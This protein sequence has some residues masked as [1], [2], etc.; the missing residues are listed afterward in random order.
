ME[1]HDTEN[2]H[3]SYTSR[4]EVPQFPK[5]QNGASLQGKHETVDHDSLLFTLLIAS[6]MRASFGTKTTVLTYHKLSSGYFGMDVWLGLPWPKLF[7]KLSCNFFKEMR[8]CR[9]PG[10]P[11]Q[12]APQDLETWFFGGISTQCG[13]G[14]ATA[15]H[16]NTAC[17]SACGRCTTHVKGVWQRHE[18]VVL[19]V[20][21]YSLQ[22][23][24]MRSRLRNEEATLRIRIAHLTKTIWRQRQMKALND[25][26]R[27]RATLTRF[28]CGRAE[29]LVQQLL[30]LS[31][32]APQYCTG[33]SLRNALVSFL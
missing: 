15:P 13:K 4:F 25:E 31:L 5:V 17:S 22:E 27:R 28:C 24:L 16:T 23:T 9:W 33:W 20:H 26:I 30:R 1:V 19:K 12:L 21:H 11:K 8:I 3:R 6:Q 18:E 32:L 14:G 7:S 2:E 29:F 10:T